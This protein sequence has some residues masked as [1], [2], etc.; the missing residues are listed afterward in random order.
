MLHFSFTF[1]SLI[2]KTK[3]IATESNHHIAL[4]CLQ[5][6]INLEIIC[7]AIKVEALEVGI[8]SFRLRN[9]SNFFWKDRRRL[10]MLF[11]LASHA[12]RA[13]F[14]SNG[15]CKVSRFVEANPENVYSKEREKWN[16]L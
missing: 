13:I 16:E 5:I 1:H 2:T 9:I 7:M 6:P 10:G 12:V 15:A 8:F 11:G 14:A 4:N 3:T